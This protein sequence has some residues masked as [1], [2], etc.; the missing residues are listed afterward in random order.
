MTEAKLREE[1]ADAVQQALADYA[2]STR[3]SRE[4]AIVKRSGTNT[5]Q[6]MDSKG[7]VLNVVV[8]RPRYA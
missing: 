6:V 4:V 2:R 5:V 8:G 7:R 3:G 1:L